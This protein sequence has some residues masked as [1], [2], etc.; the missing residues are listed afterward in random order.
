V[1]PTT[2]GTLPGTTSG[3]DTSVGSNPIT[4]APCFGGGSSAINGGVPGAPT[5]AVQPSG[6][7]QSPAGLPPNDSVYGL[8]NQTNNSGTPGAC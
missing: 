5:I 8:N 1:S 6:I 3:P 4:R 7:S 2:P